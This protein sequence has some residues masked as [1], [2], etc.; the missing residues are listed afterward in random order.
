MWTWEEVIK[1]LDKPFGTDGKKMADL[2]GAYYGMKP[3]GN[4][5][6]SKVQ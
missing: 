5:D 3:E 6:K 1:L 2:F 4:V